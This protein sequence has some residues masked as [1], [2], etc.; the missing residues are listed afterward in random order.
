MDQTVVKAEAGRKPGTRA[1]RRLRAEGRLP[2]VVYGMD[3]D[4]QPVDVSYV[5]LRDALS[6][7]AGL[8]K[9]LTLDVDGKQETVICRSIQRDPIKRVVIHADFIRIDPRK[10]VTVMVPIVLIGDDS[11]LTDQGAMIEQKRFEIELE[12]PADSIPLAIEADISNLTLDD[13]IAVGDLKLP[14]GATTQLPAEISVAA[15]V[16]SR[17]AAILDELEAEGEEGEGGDTE[18]GEDGEGG[19][20]EASDDAGSDE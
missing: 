11:G 18:A 14:E 4:P 19:D 12:V 3:Q 6:T 2:A 1:A 5:E 16:I 10:A 9:V 13:R 7:E 8:N 17:A 15:P 20:A